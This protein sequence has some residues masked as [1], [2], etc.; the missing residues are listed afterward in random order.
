VPDRCRRK[1]LIHEAPP[2]TAGDRMQDARDVPDL[3]IGSP[4]MDASGEFSDLIEIGALPDPRRVGEQDTAIILYTSGTPRPKGA[5]A[6]S[7]ATLS[8]RTWF[9][10]PVCS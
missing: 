7:I 4:S 10:P 9:S 5:M 3:M 1:V 8:I 2:K 6:T